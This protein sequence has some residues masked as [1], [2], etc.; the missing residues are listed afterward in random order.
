MIPCYLFI[1]S[2]ALKGHKLRPRGFKPAEI[3]PGGAGA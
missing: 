3:E 2:Y 1:L